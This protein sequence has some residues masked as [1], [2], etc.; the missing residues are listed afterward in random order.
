MSVLPINEQHSKK[1]LS[2]MTLEE[3]RSVVLDLNMPAFYAKQIAA[4]LYR[5]RALSIEQMTDLSKKARQTLEELYWIGKWRPEGEQ[6]S[7]DGTV[8]YLFKVLDGRLVES[9]Y[10][11]DGERATLCVSSQAGC[12]MNCSF[13]ATG[14]QGFHGNLSAS[15]IINQIL[16]IPESEKLT[17]IVFMGMGEPTDNIEPV[18]DV[19]RIMTSKWGMEWS[20]KRITVSSI[21]K[22][23]NL[24]RL[25]DETKVHIAISV[26]SPFPDER[27]ELM[28][29]EKA[30]PIRRVVELLEHYDF[31]R[32]RRC[33]VEY[34]MWRG[35]N[36]DF[37]HADALARLLKPIPGIRVN[38]IRYHALSPDDPMQPSDYDTM[39]AFR[40]RLNF[41]GITATIRSSRGED[42]MAAC[43]MLAGKLND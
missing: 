21:G 34:I 4:W 39:V 33:S 1:P 14:R 38:L 26:H 41:K 9:V 22:L 3:L 15:E 12:R 8:K 35:I 42:I 23:D 28:P 6:R 16:S 19:L 17:N 36:D 31:T 29:V 2:G 11:P 20:P 7:V 27:R 37:H 30:Y 32:Q 13:C 43:G 24:R 25:L 18:L 40:D 10:I 5:K